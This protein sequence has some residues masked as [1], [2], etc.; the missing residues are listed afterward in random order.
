MPNE[1]KPMDY[2]TEVTKGGF[3]KELTGYK[4]VNIPWEK[5]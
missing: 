5:I 4:G 3:V 2:K 1:V